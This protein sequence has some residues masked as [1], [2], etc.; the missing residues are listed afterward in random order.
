MNAATFDRTALNRMY[1]YCFTLT[2]DQDA[3]YDLL[4]DGLERY[5]RASG[6]AVD[7][8]PSFLRRIIRNRFIDGLRD[9]GARIL[10][11]CDATDPDCLAIGFSSL[12]SLAIAEQDLEHIW[13]RLDPLEREL[14]NLWALEG[15]TAREVADQLLAPLGTV[16]ARI[17]RLRRKIVRFSDR[18]G[19]TEM[20]AGGAR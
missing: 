5:M 19:G 14:L 9:R 4:Q 18:D 6:S 12:E 13:S 1:R 16:L 7:D 20:A 3:A 8:P 2:N 17:H 10:D 15:Y 11:D